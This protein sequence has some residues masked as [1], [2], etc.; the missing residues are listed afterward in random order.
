M[1]EEPYIDHATIFVSKNGVGNVCVGDNVE[2][3]I[4]FDASVIS[5]YDMKL[6]L[7]NILKCRTVVTRDKRL[8]A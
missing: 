6:F 2:P 5:T 4:N 8:T 3:F 1:R 7:M